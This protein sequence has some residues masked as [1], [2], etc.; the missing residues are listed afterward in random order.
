MVWQDG[1][2]KFGEWEERKRLSSTAHYALDVEYRLQDLDSAQPE[3]GEHVTVAATYLGRPSQHSPPYQLSL[4]SYELSR[5]E[6]T[7]VSGL[8]ARTCL[9]TVDRRLHLHRPSGFLFSINGRENTRSPL[10]HLT[11]YRFLEL[12]VGI[13]PT[14]S[15]YC[16]PVAQDVSLNSTSLQSLALMSLAS[17]RQSI[18]CCHCSP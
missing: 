1:A 14:S 16:Y 13:P 4:R 5:H 9:D 7:A 12:P 18:R 2:I 6:E 11:H 15:R 8:H 10:S 17:S 3:A